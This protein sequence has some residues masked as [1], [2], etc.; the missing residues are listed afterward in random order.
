MKKLAITLAL[1]AAPLT[2]FAG[3]P[4]YTYQVL[5]NFDHGRALNNQGFAV[6]E[7]NVWNNNNSAD[8]HG[9]LVGGG[10]SIDLGSLG[11]TDTYA[12]GLN[13]ANVVIGQSKLAGDSAGHAFLYANG[14]MRDLGTLGGT[15][16][17]ALGIN[18]QGVVVGT[19][20][21]AGGATR[22]FV[23]T[24][25]GGMRDIGTLGG[26]SSEAY[27]VSETGE[28]LGRAQTASGEWHT[29]LYKDGVMTDINATISPNVYG[30]GP[31]GELYGGSSYII[32][33]MPYYTY[34]LYRSDWQPVDDPGAIGA[35]ANG[36]IVGTTGGARA[37]A[38]LATREGTYDIDDLVAGDWTFL[39]AAD[40][41]DQGQILVYGSGT[42]V[43]GNS[44]TQTAIL[45]S[46]IPEP[47]TYAMLGLGLG[48]VALA[49]RSKGSAVSCSA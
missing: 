35:M 31:N 17:H 34:E 6:V 28:I 21:T 30:F 11:G 45:L 37:P 3:T 16:S 15:N 42:D 4:Q 32:H 14:A 12:Y 19:S 22:A 44:F 18:N 25:N 9:F 29:F 36:Y 46:P 43:H 8:A 7:R 39:Y 38:M 40:V 20:D 41:N 47:A 49:R 27:D 13:D 5:G 24:E 26:A 33:D 10:N 48:V 2:A 23:Y 1:A